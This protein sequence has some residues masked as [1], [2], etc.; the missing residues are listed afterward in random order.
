MEESSDYNITLTMIVASIYLR[1]YYFNIIIR[2]PNA[3]WKKTFLKKE[4]MH[5]DKQDVQS[6]ILR[7]LVCH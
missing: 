3:W 7:G 2:Y 1:P 5:I 4:V 6:S